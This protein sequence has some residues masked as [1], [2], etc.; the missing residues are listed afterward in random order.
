LAAFKL[1]KSA[2]EWVQICDLHLPSALHPHLALVGDG[3]WAVGGVLATS[4][5]AIKS[6]VFATC[7]AF[8]FCEHVTNAFLIL[9]FTR[10]QRQGGLH[11]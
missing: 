4:E 1:A 2:S 7:A 11:T 8:L 5:R 6:L 9:F 10:Q 3:R